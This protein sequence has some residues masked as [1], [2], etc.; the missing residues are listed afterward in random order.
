MNRWI[1]HIPTLLLGLQNPTKRSA[2]NLSM[3]FASNPTGLKAGAQQSQSYR[4]R[5]TIKISGNVQT[6]TGTAIYIFATEELTD[7]PDSQGAARLSAR[8]LS[9]YKAEHSKK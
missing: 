5:G 2:R 1:S 7:P 6:F 9:R 3:T 8:R 4:E